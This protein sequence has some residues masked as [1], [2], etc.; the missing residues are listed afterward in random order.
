[1][2]EFDQ[3]KGESMLSARKSA[4][5]IVQ[6]GDR[7]FRWRGGEVS[8]LE[9]LFDAVIALALTL[10][11][12]SIEVPSSFD[13]LMESFKKLPAFAVCFVLLTMCWYYHYLFHRRYGLE[14]FPIVILN[15]VLMFLVVFYVY[16][17][18]FLYSF[19]FAP[20]EFQIQKSQVATLMILYSGGM[21][22]IFTLYFLMYGYAY[23]KK[24]GLQLS[25]NEITLTRAKLWEH[26]WYIVVGI[27]SIVIACIPGMAPWSGM[28]YAALGPIQFANGMYWGGKIDESE[29]EEA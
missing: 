29:E 22:A 14:D 11:I 13:M 16:P 4:N 28:T 12:V 17:L 5:D 21:I 7:F 1:M 18:K 25:T 26:V 23:L 2:H 15:A 9:S 8:R 24:E 20:Q 10:I 3:S 19:L 27:V 6:Q